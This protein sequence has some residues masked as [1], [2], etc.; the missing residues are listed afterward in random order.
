[1][2]SDHSQGKGAAWP[3]P[4]DSKLSRPSANSQLGI[5][6]PTSSMAFS[7]PLLGSAIVRSSSTCTCMLDPLERVGK[8]KLFMK[9]L[10]EF[11][12]KLFQET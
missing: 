3:P 10:T 5:A 12:H 1:M 11:L 2:F 7:C 6:K 9:M 4:M 8:W